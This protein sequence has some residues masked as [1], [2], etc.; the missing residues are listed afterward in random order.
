MI[1]AQID[2]Y[3]HFFKVSKIQPI[4][5]HSVMTTSFR[6]LLQTN[7]VKIRGRVQKQN[8]KIYMARSQDKSEYRYHIHYL[9][10]F[11]QLMKGARINDKEV[12]WIVHPLYEP[13][14]MNAKMPGV[15]LRDYQI[16]AHDYVVDTGVSKLVSI[17]TGGGKQVSLDTPVKIPN[18]WRLIKDINV[19]DIVNTP[20]GDTAK[21]IG[22]Y[23]NE[24]DDFY[25]ITFADGR[26]CEC[27]I[28]H[29]W[30][31]YHADFNGYRTLNMRDI[32]KI[33]NDNLSEYFIPLVNPCYSSDNEIELPKPINQLVSEIHTWHRSGIHC[34]PD[35]YMNASFNQRLSLL[36]EIIGI[37]LNIQEENDGLDIY[38]TLCVGEV[39]I[40][41]ILTLARSVGCLANRIDDKS[42]SAIHRIH[43]TRQ[44]AYLDDNSSGS[45]WVWNDL[46]L[47]FKSIE[48]I[49][50]KVG[51]CLEVDHPD[52]LYIINDYICTHNTFTA[53]KTGETIGKR[54]L[55]MVL[56]RYLQKWIE[57]V[58]GAYGKSAKIAVLKG[59]S[60]IINLV[61]MAKEGKPIPDVI[62][63]STTTMQNYIREWE[64]HQGKELEGMIAPEE[65]YETLGIGYRII[66][67]AHQH[68]HAV[69]KNDLYTH[70]PKCVYLTATLDTNDRFM[71]FIYYLMWPLDM[72]TKQLTR[73]AY[74]NTIAVRYHHY[75]PDNVRY[76]GQQGYSHSRYEQ[77]IWKHVPSRCQYLD[78]I[79]DFVETYFVPLY[80]PGKKMLI[81]CSLVDTCIDV[82]HYLNDRFKDKQ[83]KI[84][85]FTAEDPKSVIDTN[86]ITVSTLGK[87]G[88]ALDISGLIV[89]LMTVA[90][91]EPKANIQAKGRLRDLSKK[92]GFEH[93][94]PIFGYLVGSDIERHNI[95]HNEKKKLFSPIT[96]D[97]REDMTSYVIGEPMMEYIRYG[98]PQYWEGWKAEKRFR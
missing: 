20:N 52:R 24:P 74:D 17:Y 72:R 28:D 9:E 1:V 61:L 70:C 51:R 42:L 44:L 3:S 79:G 81:F 4:F 68:F 71:N 87:S 31:V 57:D 6:E 23:D 77:S 2:V 88:T 98:K 95:Y 38:L 45:D 10:R 86:D 48:Y 65:L 75:R 62:I 22:V 56:A 33:T 36:N 91:S 49:G 80:E 40:E 67:E 90:L 96:L 83:W 55:I 21:V 58:E 43:I 47:P 76:M 59:T 94:T 15:E 39:I 89:C 8:H 7:F 25:R 32:L 93:I 46:R 64:Q 13:A 35:A 78:M 16:E 37:G 5:Y 66:D 50:K 12:T 54:T 26:S 84:S 85:K 73:P 63:V 69:F 19:G 14:D 34:I 30:S 53:L 92:P 41:Q 97:Y 60:S 27:G 29:Q 18:G 82:A 11:K